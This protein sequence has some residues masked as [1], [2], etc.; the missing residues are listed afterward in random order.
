[1]TIGQTQD[2][3]LLTGGFPCQPFSCA[4]KRKGRDDDRFLWPEML[5][6]IREV[7]PTWVIAE[8]VGGIFTQEQGMVFNQVLSDM[9]NEGYEVQPFCIPACAKDAPHRRDR[10]WFVGY[11]LNDTDRANGGQIREKDSLQ[12]ECGEALGSRMLARTDKY[13][14]YSES[15][16]Q[17]GSPIRPWEMQYGRTR[18]G[19]DWLE[20]ATFLCRVDDGVSDRVDRLKSLGNAIVPQVAF[21]IMKAV[22]EVMKNGC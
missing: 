2:I 3:D 15:T 21:E 17:Q 14:G 9:E 10:F 16:G 5:R 11:S 13:V 20:V 4:G 18:T 8:N 19:S 22:K 12:G 6:V 7:H 1:M